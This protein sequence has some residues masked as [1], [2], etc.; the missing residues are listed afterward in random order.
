M[1]SPVVVFTFGFQE[2]KAK[3]TILWS[4]AFPADGNLFSTMEKV[5]WSQLATVLNKQF[6][7]QTGLSLNKENLDFLCKHHFIV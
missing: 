2:P 3:A 7:D 4:N 1:S 6:T 5:P